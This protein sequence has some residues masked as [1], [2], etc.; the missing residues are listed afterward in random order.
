MKTSMGSDPMDETLT[1]GALRARGVC[2]GI[3]H[4]LCDRR[5]HGQKPT[6]VVRIL[7]QKFLRRCIDG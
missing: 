5:E 2:R 1:Y 4:F 7:Y 3:L 6:H